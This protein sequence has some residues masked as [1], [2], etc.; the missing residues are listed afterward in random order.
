MRALYG[1][2]RALAVAFGL[3]VAMAAANAQSFDEALTGFTAHSFS[4]TEN[5]IGAVQD[6][7][8]LFD[9][10]GKKVY[11]KEKDD[12]IADAATGQAIAGAAP[13]NL[14]PVRLNNRLRRAVEAALGG[15]SLFAE[16]AGRR[17]DAA[18]ADRKSTRLNSS[19]VSESRM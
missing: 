9:P 12:R 13:A 4:D 18:Q 16:D 3:L 10:D 14:R 15:L 8:L 17:F 11:I 7:R 6:G 5:A 19:H 2:L 1:R